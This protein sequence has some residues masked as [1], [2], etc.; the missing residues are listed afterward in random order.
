MY[1]GQF[2]LDFAYEEWAAAHRETHHASYFQIIE[3]A[4]AATWR[5]ATGIAASSQLAPRLGVDPEAGHVEA[6][7]VRLLRLSGAHAAAAE[8]YAHYSACSKRGLGST[9]LPS[10][11]YEE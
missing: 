4:V 8:Q 6:S 9:R 3:R 1:R 11:H 5:Q 2:A 7:L 10:M